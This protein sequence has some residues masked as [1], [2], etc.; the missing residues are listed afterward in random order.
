MNIFI[1]WSGQVSMAVAEALRDW[2]PKVLQSVRPW[3]SAKDIDRG[4]RWASEIGA[5]LSDTNFG[6]VC[7]SPDN[8]K[9]P[10]LLFEAGAL[11]KAVETARVATYLYGLNHSDV[12]QALAQ[13]QGSKADKNDTKSLLESINKHLGAGAL[14]QGAL[15]EAFDVWWPKLEAKLGQI[16]PAKPVVT[17]VRSERALIEEILEIVRAQERRLAVP[18]VSTSDLTT[19]V[20][21]RIPSFTAVPGDPGQGVT[22]KAWQDL[23]DVMARYVASVGHPAKGVQQLTKAIADKMSSIPHTMPAFSAAGPPGRGTSWTGR[24]PMP[25]QPPSAEGKEGGED[26]PAPPDKP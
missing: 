22:S 8:L 26:S 24:T 9:A 7:L 17:A 18:A 21:P 2:L 3:M 23:A 14:A 12:E 4:A 6:I 20:I 16:Q 5:K 13:F 15:D 10:W 11:S 25:P 19:N 1:S